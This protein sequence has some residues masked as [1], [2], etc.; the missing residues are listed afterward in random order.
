[1]SQ[2][3]K[4]LICEHLLRLKQMRSLVLYVHPTLT[5]LSRASV[6]RII[7]NQMLLPF[8]EA[9]VAPAA[10]PFELKRCRSVIIFISF[11]DQFQWELLV[12]VASTRLSFG[13]LL[14]IVLLAFFSFVYLVP[15][16]FNAIEELE[17]L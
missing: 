3:L 12:S 15:V 9:M 8:D 5:L 10:N 6:R 16:Y 4:L 7:L 13:V 14:L 11:F 17:R 1:M 2:S